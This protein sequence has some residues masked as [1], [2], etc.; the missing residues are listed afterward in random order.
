MI[1]LTAKTKLKLHVTEFYY[2]KA[3]DS[4][5][6]LPTSGLSLSLDHLPQMTTQAMNLMTV[7][8]R[9]CFFKLL[10]FFCALECFEIL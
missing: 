2:G 7:H 3:R 1:T 5:C 10:V 8:L 6:F 9:C 4:E